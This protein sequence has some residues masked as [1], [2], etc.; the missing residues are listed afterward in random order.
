MKS[1]GLC[2]VYGRDET[3]IEAARQLAGRLDVTV[4]LSQPQ[5][6]VPPRIMDLPIFKG[7]IDA[8]TGHLGAFEIVVND[9][10]PLVVSSRQA[11]A[12]DAPRNGAASP[13]DLILHLPGGAPLFPAPDNPDGSFHP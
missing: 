7:T 4:L 6:V 5:D 10:A 13:C 3:A 9:H 1:E 2:L 12:F 8:A 11:L